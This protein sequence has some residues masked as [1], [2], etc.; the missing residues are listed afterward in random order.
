MKKN[1]S[2]KG[3][4]KYIMSKDDIKSEKL[5]AVEA[6]VILAAIWGCA[7]II[8]T[9]LHNSAL[10][11]PAAVIASALEAL[12]F[13]FPDRFCRAADLCFRYRWSLA[14]LIFFVC[15]CLRLHGSSIG[16][17]DEVFP[18]QIITEETTL[19][20]VP[21]WIRS[22]E[23]SL[24]TPKY[25]SQAVNNW[26]L[27]SQQMSLS[28]TNMVL[29]FYSPVWDWTI[30]GKPLSWGFLL[31]GNEVGL[32][33]YWCMEIILLFMTAFE[34]C[35]IMTG[36]RLTALLGAVMIVLSPAIQWWVMPHMPLVILYAMALF[37][38]GYRFF[39]AERT[40]TRWCAAALAMMTAVGFVLS[41]FP[42]FQVPCGYTVLILLTVCLHRDRHYLTFS[43]HDWPCLVLPALGA[44]LILGRFFLQSREEL[45]LL[46]NTVY[47]GQRV[48]SGGN[49]SIYD[50]F[51]DFASLFLPYKDITYA[52]NCEVASYIHFAPFFLVLSP[53]LFTDKNRSG[54]RNLAVGKTLFWIIMAEAV[55]MLIGIPR[56]LGK[57]TLLGFCNRMYQVYGWTAALFTVWGFN[58]LFRYPDCLSKKEKLLW[59]LAYGA[60]W[61]LFVK[62][63][64]QGYFS[65]FVVAGHSVGTCLP[66][67][68]ALVFV[69]ILLLAFRQRQQLMT[70]LL[71]LIMFFCGATVNPIERGI[72]AVTNHPIS[73]AISEIA[74]QEPE[75]R[76][77]GIDCAF[78]LSNY[79]MANGARV[80]DAI[81]FY[82][83]V[84]KWEI[85]DPG[86]QYDDVTNRY[87]NESAVFTEGEN[88][89]EL[90]FPDSI[91][92]H[93]NPQSLKDLEIRYLFTPMDYTEL[94]TGYGI[95]CDYIT[96][97]DGYGIWK[98][99]Y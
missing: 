42:S 11:V 27:Y 97:Q 29:D 48:G 73:A 55:Y 78:F 75:S 80:L 30:L 74:V 87:A 68:T 24:A 26:R 21:R 57:I 41:I 7:W 77:L 34:M 82:P 91:L 96:G 62:D 25:L 10:I 20:G 36:N 19:Y 33:W 69:V 22:D 67:L 99:S 94:L 12:I 40:L 95:T 18:T 84:E 89:V 23:F 5:T 63:D 4:G 2:V 14:L 92:L 50:L 56:W 81:N 88:A 58:A 59:P 90:V 39:T 76:W 64:L 43:R 53:R 37:D 1:D 85:L 98:L 17:Y 35:L 28:P 51:T 8:R 32:S 86:G 45:L 38:I 46:M 71:T 49:R 31:F 72:G 70:A 13:F 54:D 93:L 79:V 3:T 44:L 9:Y 61:L 83:D 52:N 47:P 15:V 66:V 65:Q 60:F 6:L 16:I